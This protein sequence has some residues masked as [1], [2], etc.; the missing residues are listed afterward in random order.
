MDITDHIINASKK[1]IEHDAYAALQIALC[2]FETIAQY[3]WAIM[4]TGQDCISEKELE[5]FFLGVDLRSFELLSRFRNGIYHNSTL[6]KNF[7]F[8][9][10]IFKIRLFMIRSALVSR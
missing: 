5:I 9:R 8:L 1:K 2:Y 4:V 10:D 3:Q 6:I 7:F